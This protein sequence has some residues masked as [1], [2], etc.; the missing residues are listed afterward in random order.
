MM[1]MMTICKRPV[2][3]DHSSY[4]GGSTSY[5]AVSTIRELKMF[6]VQI[7]HMFIV[8][9]ISAFFITDNTFRYNRES[10]RS[11]RIPPLSLIAMIS[12]RS[13]SAHIEQLHSVV[14]RSSL[15]SKHAR[16]VG[17]QQG[18]RTKK[19]KKEKTWTVSSP[20]HGQEPSLG[21]RGGSETKTLGFPSLRNPS[22]AP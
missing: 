12:R 19:G 21:C 8:D 15:A 22:A 6:N 17:E 3:P 9:S 14:T 1:M 7:E 11:I 16:E 5:M 18:L 10:A 20:P 2:P 4:F 13:S